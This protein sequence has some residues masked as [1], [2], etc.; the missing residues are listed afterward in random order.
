MH[1][2]NNGWLR[3]LQDEITDIIT[4]SCDCPVN[5]DS[6]S[7]NCSTNRNV[8]VRGVIY[9]SSNISATVIVDMLQVRLLT[10]EEP[11]V[12]ILGEQSFQLNKQCPTKI[13][14]ALPDICN[15]ILPIK[16][17]ASTAAAVNGG[18]IGGSFVGGIIT[19][20]FICVILLVVT[21]W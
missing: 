20:V 7:V 1:F 14:L 21:V 3:L 11:L 9:S 5:L 17:T 4:A 8:L 2:Q 15:Q 12:M 16:Q 19:G 6:L 10:S 18:V 13:N